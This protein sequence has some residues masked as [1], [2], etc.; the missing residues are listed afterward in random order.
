MIAYRK[1]SVSL[2]RFRCA[3]SVRPSTSLQTVVRMKYDRIYALEQVPPRY[4]A[5]KAAHQAAV[6][7]TE[8][9]TPRLTSGQLR[10]QH[11]TTLV[12]DKKATWS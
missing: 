3:A 8:D 1:L 4:K 11:I 5:A 7:T 9:E 10:T 12:E 2:L 6:A